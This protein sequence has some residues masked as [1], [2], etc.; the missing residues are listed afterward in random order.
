L[1]H[2]DAVNDRRNVPIF[3]ALSSE[4]FRHSPRTI[5]HLA[6]SSKERSPNEIFG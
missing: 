6:G 1:H 4:G 2:L 5:Y 3:R